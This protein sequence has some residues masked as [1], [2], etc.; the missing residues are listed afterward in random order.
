MYAGN[1]WKKKFKKQSILKQHQKYKIHLHKFNKMWIKPEYNTNKI[2]LN[3]IREKLKKWRTVFTDW[4][5]QHCLDANSLFYRFNAINRLFLYKLI[6][7][8]L[9]LKMQRT[10]KD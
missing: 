6:S 1:C 10:E 9:K 2:F 5:S 3:E 7:W 8:F 4:T